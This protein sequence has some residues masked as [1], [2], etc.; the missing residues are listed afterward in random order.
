MSRGEETKKV[1]AGVFFGLTFVTIM[2]QPKGRQGDIGR[3]L[4][5]TDA[6]ISRISS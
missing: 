6:L 3:M 2:L 4:R 1:L 5:P